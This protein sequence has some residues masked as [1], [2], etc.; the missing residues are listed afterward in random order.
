MR[1]PQQFAKHFAEFKFIGYTVI[2]LTFMGCI[3][4]AR[5]FV[6][7]SIKNK[8]DRQITLKSKTSA[9]FNGP[10]KDTSILIPSHGEKQVYKAVFICAFSDCRQHIKNDSFRDSME[11]FFSNDTTKIFKIARSDWHIKKHSARATIKN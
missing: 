10:G 2:M 3:G 6:K 8:T 9:S 11:Y 5:I 1:I 4:D 7:Y